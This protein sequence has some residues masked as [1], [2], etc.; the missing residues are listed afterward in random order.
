MFLNVSNLFKGPVCK[1]DV[2]SSGEVADCNQPNPF[3]S[4]QVLWWYFTGLYC[5]KVRSDQKP[6]IVNTHTRTHGYLR[7]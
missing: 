7:V 6:R 4:S 1:L 2:V 3:D 5:V